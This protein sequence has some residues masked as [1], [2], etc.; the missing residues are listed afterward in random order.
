MEFGASDEEVPGVTE[1][2]ARR[3]RAK[4]AK[5][6]VKEPTRAESMA[7]VELTSHQWCLL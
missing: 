1:S 3:T 6:N 5:V 4:Q 7:R 2:T